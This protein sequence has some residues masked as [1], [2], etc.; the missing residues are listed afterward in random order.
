MTI[1]VQ[2][3]VTFVIDNHNG[4]WSQGSGVMIAPDIMLTAS[5][6][7]ESWDIVQGDPAA[8]PLPVPFTDIR[9]TPNNTVVGNPF[10]A[11]GLDGTIAGVSIHYND[12]ATTPFAIQ[13]AD[14]AIVKLAHPV[15]SG[16]MGINQDFT[17]GPVTY[18]GYP[19]IL[20]SA[21]NFVSSGPMVNVPDVLRNPSD[22]NIFF[23]Y[24]SDVHGP[25]ASGGASWVL[26]ANGHP[27]VVSIMSGLFA[28]AGIQAAMDYNSYNEIG[29]WMA[30]EGESPAIALLY[31]GLLGRSPDKAGLAAWSSLLVSDM[32]IPTQS[33]LN[34]AARFQSE[35]SVLNSHLNLVDGFL[36]SPEFLSHGPL[37]NAA[38]VTQLYE[39]SLGRDPE[40][41][42]LTGWTAVLDS[43]SWT[44]EQ[45]VVGISESHEA[46]HHFSGTLFG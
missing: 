4:S 12:V 21:G 2:N 23:D 46:I 44:R 18:S 10:D 26:G 22:P 5:H 32:T 3:T 15:T 37:S 36:N 20:D 19:A 24:F 9:I 27:E 40:T 30:Q 13:G 8:T 41:A 38:F 34:G 11:T 43:H 42:G 33:G 17:G 28:G 7:V 45:V 29:M 25:G 39:S 35:A 6:V 16:Y 14:F 31:Q 1:N